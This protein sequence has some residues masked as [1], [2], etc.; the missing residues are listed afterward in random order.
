MLTLFLLCGGQ[1]CLRKAGTS[2]RL[3][4]IYTVVLAGPS[5]SSEAGGASGRRRRAP[6]L[7]A[8]SP[9]LR[10]NKGYGKHW[11]EIKA[12]G[13]LLCFTQGQWSSC[14]PE[15]G[16]RKPLVLPDTSGGT[17]L[18]VYYGNKIICFMSSRNNE[19]LVS[20]AFL[21][22]DVITKKAQAPVQAFSDMV[23]PSCQWILW[24]RV[25]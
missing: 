7:R 17:V 19:A 23:F 9:G 11:G 4:R 6:A 12:R 16:F 15:R 5:C 18:Y 14:F 24:R 3:F 22:C 21:P 13:R 2:L 20:S 8:R 10:Q 1:P 25:F